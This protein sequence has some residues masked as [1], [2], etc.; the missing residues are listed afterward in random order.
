M[1][2]ARALSRRARIL[3]LDE[4]TSSISEEE[5]ARL[6]R[7]I[8][9]LTA[10]GAG[11]IFVSHRVGDIVAIADRATVL[12]DGKVAFTGDMADTR[13]DELLHCSDDRQSTCRVEAGCGDQGARIGS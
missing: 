6:F 11:V 5:T 1:E 9:E 3:L 2:I 10:G 12:R 4:P 13:A 8:R 7:I